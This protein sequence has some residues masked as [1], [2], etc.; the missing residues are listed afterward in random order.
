M[1]SKGRFLSAAVSTML[2][3]GM[4]VSFVGLG[5]IGAAPV[6]AVSCPTFVTNNSAGASYT[7]R[8]VGADGSCVLPV[9]YDNSGASPGRA[10][11]NFGTGASQNPYTIT[12]VSCGGTNCPPS[13]IWIGGWGPGDVGSSPYSI[14]Y[15]FTL[16]ASVQAGESCST[17]PLKVA[18]NVGASIIQIEGGTGCA[19]VT[20]PTVTVTSTVTARP[21]I[22]NTKTDTVTSTAT[23]TQ[24]NSQTTISTAT[25][26]ST[27]KA[28]ATTTVT[29]TNTQ[30]ITETV[31]VTITTTHTTTVTV[32]GGAGRPVPL[33]FHTSTSSTYD[34][35]TSSSACATTQ[36]AT[37]TSTTTIPTTTAVTKTVTV[38][39]TTIATTT[40]TQ[41][42][43]TTTTVTVTSTAT[44][45]VTSQAT[46]TVT[47]QTFSTTDTDTT[48]TISTLTHPPSVPEFS[49]G[50]IPLLLLAIPLMVLLR[51]RLVESP[52]VKNV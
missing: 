2:L 7:L 35:S 49:L 14:L 40:V 20:C 47:V 27:A 42:V 12:I 1:S 41:T 21:T 25:Q 52:T 29:G 45:T 36:T 34:T 30:T 6:Y 23:Q 4:A 33:W 38:P 37:V 17:A 31:T 26:T 43:P 5:L 51:R 10:H 3:L 15:S 28:T 48:I 11:V 22:T 32:G 16:D 18:G 24:T 13:Q 50:L 19:P 46:V 39:T 44:E 9:S 8:I